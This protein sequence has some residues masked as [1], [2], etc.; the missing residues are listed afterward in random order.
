MA[1]RTIPK[2]EI[3]ESGSYLM[4]GDTESRVPEMERRVVATVAALKKKPVYPLRLTV[5]FRGRKDCDVFARLIR[6]TIRADDKE[7]E[8]KVLSPH[9]KQNDGFIGDLRTGKQNKGLSAFHAQHWQGM[10]DFVQENSA[11][12]YHSLRVV[13]TSAK[14]YGAFA[15]VVRQTLTQ[16]TKSI[17]FPM[18]TP[19]KARYKK[20][21]SDLP[22]KHITPRY[23]IYIVS[24][25]RSYSR[26]TSKTLEGLGVPYYIVIEPQDFDAYSRVIDVKKILVL[27]FATAPQN[28]TGPGR[29]R[30]WCRDHAWSNGFNRH[31]VMDDNIH[32][33]YRLH[34]NGRYR[35]ADGAIFRAAE[36]FV[37]RYDNVWVA[38]FQYNFFCPKK[39]KYPP[40]VANTRIYSCLLIDNRWMLELNGKE[41]LW[42]ERYNED[43]ILSL[44]VLENDSVTIQFNAFLQ[45]KIGTQTMRG[46]NSEVFYDLEGRAD[47]K[48]REV[49][50]Y[51]P[52]GTIRKTLN[53]LSIY[54]EVTTETWKFGRFHH[55]VDYRKYKDN[56]LRLRKGVSVPQGI[57]DYGMKLVTMSKDE[58]LAQRDAE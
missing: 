45:G 24:K 46:G 44:D 7:I 32:G 37:D 20:W 11:W 58:I 36:D 33:F 48:R 29:A 5:K 56:P 3:G 18:W 43:T 41:F 50:A 28:P 25:G 49:S 53:L 40:F 39:S 6:Q 4:E 47:I 23:P 57:N 22:R 12:T 16:T 13:F 1:I 2:P 14:A 34:K 30:N 31:W 9:S 35:V 42:R 55:H 19:E 51:N 15:K 52:G 38:G 10:P 27:P 26:L 21:V 17:Y 8:F 54:L